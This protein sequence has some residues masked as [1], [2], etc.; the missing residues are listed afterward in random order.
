VSRSKDIGTAAE[1]AVVR[2]LRANGFPAAERR[3][4]KGTLDEGDITGTP[5]ICWEVKARSRPVSDTQV[6]EWLDEVAD[7]RI[8]ANADIGVVVIRRPGFGPIR[9]GSWWAIM[10]A[11][12]VVALGMD[13]FSHTKKPALLD[14]PVRMLLTDAVRLLRLDGY[15]EEEIQ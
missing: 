15:G 12:I 8:N 10:P 14:F 7:E 1:T 5:G 4:L 6:G 11:F 9:A 13:E 2:F 3:A